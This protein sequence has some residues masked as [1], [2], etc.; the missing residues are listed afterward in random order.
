[1]HHVLALMAAIVPSVSAAQQTSQ[2][3]AAYERLASL[4]NAT[5][6]LAQVVNAGAFRS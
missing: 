6:A 5:I 4:P 1:M 2:P 3:A